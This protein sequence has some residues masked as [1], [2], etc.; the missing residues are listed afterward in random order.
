MKFKLQ[1][2]QDGAIYRHQDGSYSVETSQGTGAGKTITEAL[3]SL[4]DSIKPSFAKGGYVTGESKVSIDSDSGYI[5]PLNKVKELIS[6]TPVKKK[7]TKKS[8]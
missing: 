2:Y 4:T 8:K 3:Q 6:E 1:S 5:I 7:R